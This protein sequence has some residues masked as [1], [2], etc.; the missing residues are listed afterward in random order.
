[1]TTEPRTIEVYATFDNRFMANPMTSFAPDVSAATDDDELTEDGQ[2]GLPFPRATDLPPHPVQDAT[3]QTTTTS[4]EPA[5][6]TIEV[7]PAPVQPG[8][9]VDADADALK[10]LI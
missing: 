7:P 4:Q 5:P 8:F 10:D 9:S 6:V 1:M 2:G 3:E